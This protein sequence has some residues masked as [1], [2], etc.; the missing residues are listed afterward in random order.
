MPKKAGMQKKS[1]R[2]DWKKKRRQE[3]LE[4]TNKKSSIN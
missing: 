2:L 4:P 1:N 3:Y